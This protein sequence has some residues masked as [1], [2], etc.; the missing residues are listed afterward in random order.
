MQE[1]CSLA[2][3]GLEVNLSRGLCGDSWNIQGV[4]DEHGLPYLLYELRRL[5]MDTIGVSEMRR[6]GSGEIT[7]GGYTYHWSAMSSGAHL[8]GLAVGISSQLQLF[9]MKGSDEHVK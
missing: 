2:E 7:S 8:R 3:P 4:C 6:P 5:R 9:V 1:L